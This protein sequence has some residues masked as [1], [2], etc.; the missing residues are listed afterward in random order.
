MAL[1]TLA[2]TLGINITAT[3]YEITIPAA[4]VIANEL[5]KRPTIPSMNATGIK[6][7]KRTDEMARIENA[8]SLI[9][10]KEASKGFLPSSIFFMIFS[11]T[12]MASSIKI[13]MASV[14]PMSVRRLRSYPNALIIA[15]VPITD[16]GI[17]SAET[18]VAVTFLKKA[19]TIMIDKKAPKIRSKRT[20]LMLT[21][22]FSDW[23][24]K[25]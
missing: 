5:K 17:A 24:F 8:T 7:A 3:K 20:L 4:T 25:S 23:S 19:N 13:P 6:T 2:P 10:S 12:T 22:I 21:I 18:M 11:I 16:V 14:R 15:N 1:N 9:P